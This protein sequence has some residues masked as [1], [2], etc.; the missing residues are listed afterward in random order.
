MTPPNREPI[1]L[2]TAR[3]LKK[4]FKDFSRM[5][6]NKERNLERPIYEFFLVN[7]KFILT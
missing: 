7:K 6:Y 2:K 5:K 1:N 3:L 4:K